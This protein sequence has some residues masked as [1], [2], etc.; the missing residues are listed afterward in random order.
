[1][2]R[3]IVRIEDIASSETLYEGWINSSTGGGKDL[4]R[5]VIEY[6]KNLDA[7]LKAL[8]EKLLAGTWVPDK[9]RTFWLFTEG[10]WR[11][12]HTVG[13][14]DR[15][16]HYALIKHFHL[17]SHFVNRTFGSIK[18]R[19]T[20][21]ANKQVRRDIHNSGY[22]LCIKLDIHH[23]Y[24]S[25]L[26][27]KFVK[28]LRQRYKGEVAIRLFESVIWAYK[29]HLDRGISI[30]SQTSQDGGNFYLTPLDYLVLYELKVKYFTRYVDDIVIFVK[31]KREARRIIDRLKEFVKD[32]GLEFGKIE[33]FPIAARRVDFCSYAVNAESVKLRDRTKKRFI[34][35]LRKLNS[36]PQKGEFERN[37]VCSYLGLLQH[38]DSYKLLKNLRYEYN[39][40]F[41]R[42]NRFAKGKG[43]KKNDTAGTNTGTV[44]VQNLL[45]SQGRRARRGHNRRGDRGTVGSYQDSA[46]GGVCERAGRP[47]ADR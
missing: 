29:P 14:E 21:K 10:K 45:Q 38:A 13:V 24:P 27:A 47:R 34:K 40:V 20:L 46:H 9:G 17:S 32:Y 4:R 15:I 44:G 31:D 18:G 5:D 16:V 42:I 1:M 22:E 28:L 33:L 43:N 30:G 3:E 19:G 26:K 35:S 41:R 11:E 23:Y 7:N 8:Q 39:S 12:I 6:A 25:A 2:K 37:S 36:H